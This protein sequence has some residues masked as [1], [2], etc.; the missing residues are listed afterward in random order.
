[1]KWKSTRRPTVNKNGMRMIWKYA[2]VDF[3]K[4][5]SLIDETNWYLVLTGDVNESLINWETKFMEIIVMCIPKKSLSKRRN[6]PWM[7]KKLMRAIRK[8]NGFFRRARQN[9][10]QSLFNRYKQQR[11]KVVKEMRKAKGHF[12]KNF[13]PSS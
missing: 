5:S 4:A 12:F 1:M 6:L 3:T 11:N 10:N 13:N 9:E 2:R 7:T 8:R